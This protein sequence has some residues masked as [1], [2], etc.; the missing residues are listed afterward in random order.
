MIYQPTMRQSPEEFY[1]DYTL[2]IDIHML[3]AT[4]QELKGLGTMKISL[5]SGK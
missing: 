1:C 2:K 5:T 3:F 4:V